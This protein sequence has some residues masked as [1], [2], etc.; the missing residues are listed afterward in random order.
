MNGMKTFGKF[1]KRA[2]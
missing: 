2:C 1:M